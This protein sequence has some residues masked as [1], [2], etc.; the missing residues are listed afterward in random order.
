MPTAPVPLTFPSGLQRGA[1]NGQNATGGVGERLERAAYHLLGARKLQFPGSCF[2]RTYTGTGTLTT[3]YTRVLRAAHTYGARLVMQ[4]ATVVPQ[5]TFKLTL[6]GAVTNPSIALPGTA[7]GYS[8]DDAAE[9]SMYFVLGSNVD[10]ER[11]I[12]DLSLALEFTW[13]DPVA[14]GLVTPGIRIY[15]WQIIP[16]DVQTVTGS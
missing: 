8:V 4:Y 6:A 14:G 15:S 12:V 11:A 3:L 16:D 1:L 13:A 7:N 10:S 2:P 9:A 5:M